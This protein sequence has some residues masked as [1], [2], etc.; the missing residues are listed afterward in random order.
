MGLLGLFGQLFSQGLSMLQFFFMIASVIIGIVVGL[1]IWS[2]RA[3]LRNILGICF[4]NFFQRNF[5]GLGMEVD[6]HW[7]R[8]V[9]FFMLGLVFWNMLEYMY[10][11]DKGGVVMNWILRSPLFRVL[12][13]CLGGIIFIHT[14]WMDYFFLNELIGYR[15]SLLH[16][17]PLVEHQA[18]LFLTGLLIGGIFAYLDSEFR[19]TLPFF[20]GFAGAN[21]AL[22]VWSLLVLGVKKLSGDPQQIVYLESFY[23]LTI[24]IVG[25]F[26]YYWRMSPK[27]IR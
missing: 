24:T 17:I 15:N 9:L 19:K 16:K 20:Y 1:S 4:A 18:F 12:V 8:H 6:A 27:T 11:N 5:S 13:G 3:Y 2:L 10:K 21:V 7:S 23:A 22:F 25:F 14:I 26:F